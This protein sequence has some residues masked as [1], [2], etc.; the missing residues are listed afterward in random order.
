MFLIMSH[1]G[2]SE[3]FGCLNKKR[4]IFIFSLM[5]YLYKKQNPVMLAA[6]PYAFMFSVM[7]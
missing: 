2:T 4:E 3:S 5:V 6:L 1:L 7:C